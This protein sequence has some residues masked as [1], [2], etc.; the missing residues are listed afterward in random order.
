MPQTWLF[1][2]PSRDFRPVDDLL[3]LW[4]YRIPVLLS[5]LVHIAVVDDFDPVYDVLPARNPFL[6]SGHR[7]FSGY[8]GRFG[9]NFFSSLIPVDCYSNLHTLLPIHALLRSPFYS[10]IGRFADYSDNRYTFPDNL[11]PG[12]LSP[13]PPFSIN[14]AVNHTRSW[15]SSIGICSIFSSSFRGPP[16][17]FLL[18]SSSWLLN[19]LDC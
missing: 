12:L 1:I 13:I 19:P 16:R 10:S 18:L 11:L 15:R 17:L 5:L 8:M 4:I 7:G 9:R 14:G 2:L 6:I 3:P